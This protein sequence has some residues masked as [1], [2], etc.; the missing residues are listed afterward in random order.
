MSEIVEIVVF[1]ILVTLTLV[2]LVASQ[3]HAVYVT[4]SGVPTIDVMNRRIAGVAI[5]L[6]IHAVVYTFAVHPMVECQGEAGIGY[7]LPS[8]ILYLPVSLIAWALAEATHDTGAFTGTILVAGG[9][10]YCAV[11]YWF[12]RRLDR[13]T[14][15]TM[16]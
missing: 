13:A 1:L 4:R 16:S 11:G 12:G 15:D 6:V 3:R 14:A 5:A 10:W 2:Y 7:I 8:T 9:V